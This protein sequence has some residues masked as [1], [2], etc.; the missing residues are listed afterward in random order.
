MPTL[1]NQPSKYCKLKVGKKQ[2]AVVYSHGKTIYLGAY[3]SP[4]SRIAYTRFIAE[5]KTEMPPFLTKEEAGVEVEVLALAFLDYAKETLSTV[6]YGHVNYCHHRNAVKELLKLYGDNVPAD[7]FKPSDLKLFRQELIRSRRFCRNTIN[8]YVR[9]IV[10]IFTWGVEEEYVCPNTALALKAVKPLREGHVGT[11]DNP[12]R[13]E[14]PDDVIKRTLPFMPPAIVAMIKIQR[15]TGMRPSEVFNMRVG[16]IDKDSDPELWFYKLPHHKTEKKTK[17]KKVVPL[18]KPEQELLTPYLENKKPEAAVFSPGTAMA[19][20]NAERKANRKTKITPSQKEKSEA[21]AKKPRRY[22]EFYNKDS[23]RVAIDH[24]IK[25]ANKTLPDDEK[26][27]H[28][29]PYQLRHTT[30][31]TTKRYPCAV[32]GRRFRFVEVV[33]PTHPTSFFNESTIPTVAFYM[34]G[35]MLWFCF[36]T[37]A[38]EITR[39]HPVLPFFIGITSCAND[40]RFQEFATSVDW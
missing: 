8:D 24:A 5:N 39:F 6:N 3:G 31:S 40:C 22:N 34:G 12:A 27:P 32:Y 23:Y 29:T 2:Y 25:K 18:G 13:E 26:I 7:E 30:A 15:L 35:A 14:V 9:R 33:S 37:N 19:E 17:V 16:E 36:R 28:W 10:Q 4:E 11:Y 20:R 21:R 1:K 38:Y